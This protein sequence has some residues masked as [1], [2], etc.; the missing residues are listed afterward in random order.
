MVRYHFSGVAGSGMS[1]LAQLMRARGHAV[2]G[3]DRALDAGKSAEVAA[4]LRDLGVE[5]VRQD[6]RA[7]TGGI[8]RFVYSS[9]VESDTPEM[10]AARALGIACVPRP[11]LLAQAVTAGQPGVAVAGTSGKSTIVGMVARLLR[12]GGGPAPRLGGAGA[13][14]ARPR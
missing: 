5:L 12:G 4:R 11:A 2:Q 6:G 9:A 3:S 10:R 13:A 14:G 8:D 7:I 1:P